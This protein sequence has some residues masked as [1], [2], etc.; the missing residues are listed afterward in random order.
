MSQRRPTRWGATI[1]RAFGAG[2]LG[3]LAAC[4]GCESPTSSA[5]G[6]HAPT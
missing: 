1:G 5:T 4:A 2:I 6:G 3:I